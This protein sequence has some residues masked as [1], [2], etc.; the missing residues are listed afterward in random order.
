MKRICFFIL[1]IAAGFI[2]CGKND[3]YQ[4]HY[5]AAALA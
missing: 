4:Y 5:D 3:D 1:V 2:S